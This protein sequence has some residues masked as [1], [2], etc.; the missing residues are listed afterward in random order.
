MGG[1]T[2]GAD[3]EIFLKNSSGYVPAIGLVGG[4]K[5]EPKQI[6]KNTWVQEDN[7]M[8]EFNIAPQ[9][10]AINFSSCISTAL[11]DIKEHITEPK[12]LEMDITPSALFSTAA[13]S[14]P[15]A[16]VFGCDPDQNAWTDTTNKTID[17]SKMENPNLRV[18]GGHV[19][20]GGIT[21]NTHPNYKQAIV[22]L[23]DAHLG[24]P[25][26]I[27]D[28]DTRRR[29]LY[30]K[31]GSYRDKTYGLEYRTLSNFWIENDRLSGWVGREAIRT[32]QY[33]RTMYARYLGHRKDIQEIINT[34]NTHAAED[35]IRH[36][37]IYVPQ[38]H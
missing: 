28:K 32:A 18:A 27:L 10:N 38:T 1:I 24:V 2:I 13:L 6:T 8:L 14:H 12:K 11:S 22:R 9:P 26:V 3:P 34:G 35:F 29:Q 7:V 30:G 25:S 5:E 37:G 16:K 31:A 17:A 15:Q 4:T 36:F 23:L 21:D 20:I 33:W 19:H